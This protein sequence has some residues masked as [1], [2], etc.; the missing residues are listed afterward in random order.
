MFAI[1][2]PRLGWSMDEGTFSEWLKEPG[3]L[4]SKGDMVFVLE[5]EKA[6]QEI[7][8]FDT[9]ILHI[10]DDAPQFGDTVTV[11]QVIGFLLE[12]GDEPPVSARSFPT[13]SS[14]VTEA[15]PDSSTSREAA[16]DHL[17]SPTRSSGERIVATP[18]ARRRARELDVDLRGVVGTGR[19][20]RIR[21]RDLA[22]QV[23]FTSSVTGVISEPVGAGRFEAATGIRRTI[24]ARMQSA[25]HQ[26]VPVTLTTRVDASQIVALR[27]QLK[28]DADATAV[29]T[30]TDILV[31]LV[32]TTLPQCPSLNAS[33]HND[34]IYYYDDINIAIAVDTEAG[35]LAPVI[36]GASELTL[37]EIA[38]RSSTLIEAARAGTLTKADLTG[39]TMTVTNLGMFGIDAFTPVINLPQSAIL[40]IGRIV[41]EPVVRN[42]EVVPGETMT[43]SLTFD[44]RVLD[45]APAARWLQTLSQKI[46]SLTPA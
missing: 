35:L 42:D 41:R 14:N 28:P 30:V 40:G 36:H 26:T 19:N 11:G 21:E 4:V 37:N 39:G 7:E 44:H 10:P 9:G 46:E 2:V 16:A 8:S 17:N 25:S 23:S 34:G 13:T 27:R 15:T 24:A 5:G 20:G 1:T 33:W 31:Q 22:G 12:E 29:P 38:E 45:G 6:V 3:E 32:A 18:R 43:L